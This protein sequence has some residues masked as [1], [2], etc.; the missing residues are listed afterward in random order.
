MMQLHCV[1]ANRMQSVPALPNDSSS[2]K[3]EGFQHGE[4]LFLAGAGVYNNRRAAAGWIHA[5]GP[6]CFAFYHK[7][8]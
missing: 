2:E 4:C 8:E 1:P 3:G 5:S 6:R 7:G